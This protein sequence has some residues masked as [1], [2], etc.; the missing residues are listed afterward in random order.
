MLRNFFFAFLAAAI[1]HRGQPNR[2]AF[3]GHDGPKDRHAGNP[4]DV[5]DRMVQLD[6]HFIEAFLNA[7]NPIFL[8]AFESAHGTRQRTPLTNAFV[9]TERSI[10]QT[11]TV[12]TLDPLANGL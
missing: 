3:T 12:Q 8:F 1:S 5:R 11:A 9:G 7:T 4:S 2:I 6:V 10:Q